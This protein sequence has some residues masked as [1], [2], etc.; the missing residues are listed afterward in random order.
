LDVPPPASDDVDEEDDEVEGAGAADAC[1]DAAAPG[2]A[3]ASAPDSLPASAGLPSAPSAAGFAA[4][5]LPPSRKSVTYQ[6][7]PLSWNAGAVS[8]LRKVSAPQA[9]QTVSGASEN[10]WMTS[11]SWPQVSQR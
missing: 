11:F 9:G 3:F 1:D 8:C 10:F 5:D 2:A 6:P 4:L 7:L